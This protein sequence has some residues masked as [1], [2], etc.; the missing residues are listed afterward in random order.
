MVPLD[1]PS[2]K[3]DDPTVPKGWKS[4]HVDGKDVT[5][6]QSPEGVVYWSR[7][8]ALK[9]LLKGDIE[10]HSEEIEFIKN[11]LIYDGWNVYEALPKGWMYKRKD[12]RSMYLTEN[13]EL[14]DGHNKVQKLIAEDEKFT[15]E[16]QTNIRNFVLERCASEKPYLE[17]PV[18]SVTKSAVYEMLQKKVKEGSEK[19]KADA[20]EELG[21]KG[22]SVHEY[23]P[24]GWMFRNSS[25]QLSILSAEGDIFHSYKSILQHLNTSEKYGSDAAKRFMKFSGGRY[26]RAEVNRPA[27]SKIFT[28]RQYQEALKK[29]NNSE[30][31]NEIKSYYLDSGWIQHPTLLPDN[32]LCR[33]KPGF[34][35][36]NYITA[37]GEMLLSTKEANKY[38][39]SHGQQMVIELKDLQALF[40]I[41]HE[42]RLF[43]T[44]MLTLMKSEVKNEVNTQEIKVENDGFSDDDDDFDAV[45][46]Y[47]KK[48]STSC[49]DTK[50][51]SLEEFDNKT[52]NHLAQFK[53]VFEQLASFKKRNK[54]YG[55]RGA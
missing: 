25:P 18:K 20:L 33:Q 27:G 36:L 53:G 47:E 45:K 39:E 52:N 35:Q 44:E 51:Y 38:L 14:I 16:D 37:A 7:R 23:L 28:L 9:E 30:E 13:A 29:E 3:E 5:M 26:S 4:R 42:A 55:E 1:D 31:V 41:N 2:W 10:A 54:S 17:S 11:S 49:S 15:I 8:A 48:P 43:K 12:T 22:W 40:E 34:T 21:S 19:E 50:F 32:W 24:E 6:L 46:K